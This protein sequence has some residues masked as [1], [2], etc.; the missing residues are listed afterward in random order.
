MDAGGY[1]IEALLDA[2]PTAPGPMGGEMPLSWTDI[3]DYAQATRAITE[4]WEMKLLSQF[5][6][7][8][9]AAKLAGADVFAIDPVD[10][11]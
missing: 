9:L 10:Q 3:W 11:V 7:E 4:P 1:L 6:R 8:Y 2:G 5:S